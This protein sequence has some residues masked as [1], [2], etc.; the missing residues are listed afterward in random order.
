MFNIVRILKT[1]CILHR[2]LPQE[3]GMYRLPTRQTMYVARAP[4][5]DGRLDRR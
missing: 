5:P 4:P 2:R 3:W 1:K